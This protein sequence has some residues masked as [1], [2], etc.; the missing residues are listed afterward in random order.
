MKGIKYIKINTVLIILTI[1]FSGLKTNAQ[2]QAK[3]NQIAD[4]DYMKADA[5]LNAIYKQILKQYA[6]DTSFISHLKASQRIWIKFRDAE[7]LMKYP[8]RETY[9]YGS[10]QSSCEANYLEQFTRDRIKTLK[11][12]IDGIEEGDLCS[13]SVKTK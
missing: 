8:P 12:W 9:Y 1:L 10:A 6:S 4:G 13:G 7:L 5:E 2:S 11:V 3:M